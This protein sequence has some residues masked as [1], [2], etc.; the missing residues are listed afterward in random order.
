MKDTLVA[1]RRQLALNALQDVAGLE[2]DG[3]SVIFD[4][5]PTFD[6]LARKFHRC[7]KCDFSGRHARVFFNQRIDPCLH[8]ASHFGQVRITIVALYDK[9]LVGDVDIDR[10]HVKTPDVVSIILCDN[11][12]LINRAEN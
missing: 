11:D 4:L 1:G 5:V 8:Q 12:L 7:E 3:A 10:C 2:Q 6:G 9:F